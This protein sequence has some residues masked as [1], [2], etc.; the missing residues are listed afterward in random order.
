MPPLYSCCSVFACVRVWVCCAPKLPPLQKYDL[1]LPVFACP[2]L[3]VDTWAYCYVSFARVCRVLYGVLLFK[4]GYILLCF[5]SLFSPL[6]YGMHIQDTIK[7]VLCYCV[8]I[9]Q[10]DFLL[11]YIYT[12]RNRL[13]N[14]ELRVGISRIAAELAHFNV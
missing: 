3:R 12:L 5:Q 6:C 10:A 14:R 4:C 2:L 7:I 9:Q 8:L 11:V 1:S 13:G